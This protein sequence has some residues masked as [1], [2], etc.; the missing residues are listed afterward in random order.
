MS[1]DPT[2]YNSAGPA[3]PLAI[4][5]DIETLGTHPGAAILEICA[6]TFNPRTAVLGR[7]LTLEIDLLSCI[8]LG[9]EC[10]P[11]T[12]AWHL[13]R[14]Y[15]GH[16]RGIPIRHALERLKQ[17]IAQ[18]P[19][20]EVWAWGMD[21][22]RPMLDAACLVAGVTGPESGILWPYYL[23]RDA[24][25]LW[26]TV[27]PMEKPTPKVHRATEDVRIQILDTIRALM[28]ITTATP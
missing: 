16:L 2:A 15:A 18:T 14:Q 26:H 8:S 25:T 3:S 5:L 20:A 23:G 27:F 19:G 1:E 22:E 10:D 11:D 28:A 6:Q 21:F 9:Y 17:F 7:P 4:M 13:K 12:A 24:R